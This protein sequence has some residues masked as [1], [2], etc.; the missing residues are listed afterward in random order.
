M[1]SAMQ[2]PLWNSWIIGSLLL[3]AGLLSGCGVVRLAYGE[4]PVLAY[5][6]LDA[7]AD[8]NDLLTPRVRTALGEWFS[9]HGASQL[10]D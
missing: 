4:G 2:R 9:W 10:P 5:W 3:L 1:S 7:Y 8:F 6:W